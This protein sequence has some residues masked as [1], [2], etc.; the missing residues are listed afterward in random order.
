MCRI[1]VDGNKY[2]LDEAGLEGM[3]A[4][5]LLMCD[6]SRTYHSSEESELFR[7]D[8]DSM[9]RLAED[10]CTGKQREMARL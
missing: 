10:L 9:Q 8:A 3:R 6:N 4:D 5:V 7:R 1:R 2:S